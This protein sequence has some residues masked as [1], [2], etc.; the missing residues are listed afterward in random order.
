MSRTFR[1]APSILSADF[2]CL[3]EEVRNVV[4]AGYEV[5]RQFG[6][7]K[8]EEPG[9]GHSSFR[10]ALDAQVEAANA[11]NKL[12]AGAPQPTWFGLPGLGIM[13][14]SVAGGREVSSVG[15]FGAEFETVNL[16][17]KIVLELDGKVV[18]ESIQKHLVDWA[19]A[20][21]MPMTE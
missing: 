4:A 15:R 14:D 10:E 20:H 12:L 13:E 21:G 8:G 5:S 18:F 3:G 19:N 17:N 11:V 1:I 7:R 9:A 2:A 16:N 6:Y